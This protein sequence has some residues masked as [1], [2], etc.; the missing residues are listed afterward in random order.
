M[1]NKTKDRKFRKGDIVEV[2]AI[3][4]TKHTTRGLRICWDQKIVLRDVQVPERYRNGF[5]R[6]WPRPFL[7][8]PVDTPFRGVV[9]GW[10]TRISGYHVYGTRKSD[11]YGPNSGS[12]KDP[13]THKV[14]MVCSMTTERW[15][16]PVACL[17]EDLRAVQIL[18]RAGDE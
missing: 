12:I 7:K 5:T 15:R 10:S 4:M 17:E 13:I 8:Y 18:W 14:I 11:D 16:E 2:S 9:V 1:T 3:V 6:G